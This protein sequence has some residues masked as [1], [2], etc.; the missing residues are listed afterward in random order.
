MPRLV[1]SFGA[2]R[3]IER[4]N[5]EYQKRVEQE[6]WDQT[7]FARKV[8]ERSGYQIKQP[9]ISEILNGKVARFP[10]EE[11]EA[12]CIGLGVT[13]ESLVFGRGA[14]GEDWSKYAPADELPVGAWETIE[15]RDR[16]IAARKA[17]IERRA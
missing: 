4:L 10:L 12:L 8:Q 7:E 16:R 3:F 14:K 1:K 6:G 5:A 9:R 17:A 11:V 15:E 2:S 13:P